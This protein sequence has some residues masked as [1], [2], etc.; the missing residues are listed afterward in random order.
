MLPLPDPP[1]R[2]QRVELRA[3]RATDVEAVLAAGRDPSI[4][5]YRY[6]L[7]HTPSAAAA[8]LEQ[9]D[10][11]RASDSRLELAITERAMIVGSVSLCD[12]EYGNGM[13]RY[14]L[15]PSGRGRGL[16]TRAVRL[17]AAWVFRALP[18]ER[19]AAYVE[20]D[21]DASA[22]VLERAGFVREG[23]LRRHMLGRDGARVDSLLYGLLPGDL[24][25]PRR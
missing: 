14:W 3:W 21:N 17:L 1:L 19:L 2:D 23:R 18:V 11:E 5:R 4:T 8:W 20:P 15:L 7:P 6:S 16:A 10:A 25:S 12:L 24:D 9:I 22:A 13:L